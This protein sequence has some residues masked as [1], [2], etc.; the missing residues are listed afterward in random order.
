MKLRILFQ[1]ITLTL[2]NNNSDNSGNYLVVLLFSQIYQM[3]APNSCLVG[4][5]GHGF[6]SYECLISIHILRTEFRA[7]SQG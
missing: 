6:T 2:E 5:G 7:F 1:I 4:P 3:V